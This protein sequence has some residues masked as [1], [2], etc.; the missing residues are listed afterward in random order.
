MKRSNE[1][2]IGQVIK[3]LFK[4]YHIQSRVHDVQIKDMWEQVM[5]TTIMHYTS[6]IKL[7]DGILTLYLTSAPLKQ[8]LTYMKDNIK[9][10]LNEEFGEKVV[11]EILIR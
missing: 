8:D 4:T 1:R 6:D 10:R 7:R 5:G 3:E 2:G 9:S 11:K